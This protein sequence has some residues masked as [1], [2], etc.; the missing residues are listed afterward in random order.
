MLVTAAAAWSASS[1]P[2]VE[3]QATAREGSAGCLRCHAGIEEMHPA[4]KLECVDCHGGDATAHDKVAAHVPRQDPDPGDER[5]PPADADL[6]W[7]R[8]VNPMDLR[9]AAQT[10]GACHANQVKHVH[11]SLH[12]T[13]AGHLS[14][15]FYEMGL[16]AKKGSTYAVF[17]VSEGD[18][19]PGD[20]RSLVQ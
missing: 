4:A 12:A 7:R 10:C 6:A 8:F 5:V 9:V 14:D 11:A 3:S 13:T 1:P 19:A 16:N 20:V 15:G 17:H 2:R 18:A